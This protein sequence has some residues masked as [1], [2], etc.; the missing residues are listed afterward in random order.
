MLVCEMLDD[1][2]RIFRFR[3]HF[4]DMPMNRDERRT[5][6]G[7]VGCGEGEDGYEKEQLHDDAAP[8]PR[9]LLSY[10]ARWKDELDAHSASLEL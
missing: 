1:E 10:I 3:E 9:M 2:S 5:G 4:P 6:G 8:S 7:I